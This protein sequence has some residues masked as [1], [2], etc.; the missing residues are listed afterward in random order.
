MSVVRLQTLAS[1]RQQ[2]PVHGSVARRLPGRHALRPVSL[3]VCLLGASPL[4]FALPEG[5]TPTHGQVTVQTPAAGQMLIH[6]STARA[7]LDWTSFSIAAGERVQVVQ[8]D[9]SSVLLNRVLGDNPSQIYGALQSNGSVWLINPRGIVFGANSR[10][11]VGGLVASTLTLSEDALSSGRLQLGMGAGGAGEL[12]S[13]GQITA[14]DGTVA[15]VAPRLFHTGQIEAR[16]V[17]LAAASE[18]LVDVEGDGLVFFNVRNDALD[19]RLEVL[20][21]VRA[22]GG[23]AEFRAAARAGFAD[24]VLNL[25]GVVQARSLGALMGRVVVDGGAS[26]VTRIG[27]TV[28]ATGSQGRGGDVLVQGDKILLTDSA[29]LDTSGEAGGGRLRV[30]GG[31]Q[32]RDDSVRNASMVNVARGARL[33]ANALQQGDGGEL[34]VWSDDATRFFG[35]ADARGGLTGGNGGL[36]E[37]SGKHHLDFRGSSDR[38]A[39]LGLTGLLLL[40]PTNLEIAADSP[41]IDGSASP[42]TNDL[43]ALSLLFAAPGDN[44]RITATAVQTQLGLGNVVLQ[45]NQN[46]SVNAP[47]TAAGANSLTLQAGNNITVGQPITLGGALTLSASDAGATGGTTTGAVAVNAAINVTGT[48]TLTRVGT[49]VHTVA[50][51]LTAGSLALTGALDVNG[52]STWALGA[53]LGTSAVAV[54]P[55]G[56]LTIPATTLAAGAVVSVEAG[57][58]LTNNGANTVSSLALAGT[59]AGNTV[60][61]T[62]SAALAGGSTV[63]TALTAS[64]DVTV[65]GPG[66]STVLAAVTADNILVNS[67]TL[68]V[69]N[70]GAAGSLTATTSVAVANAA[71]LAFNRSGSTDLGAVGGSGTVRVDGGTLRLTAT[72]PSVSNVNVLNGATLQY[73]NGAVNRINTSATLSVATGGTLTLGD[74]NQEVGTLTLGGTLTA[75]AQTLK[76]GTYNLQAGATV[77][78]PLDAGTLIVQGNATLNAASAA[79]TITVQGGATLTRGATGD[80]A[81]GADVTVNAGGSL[82]LAANDA[83]NSLALAGTLT[84]AGTLTTSSATLTAGTVDAALT[85]TGN[86]VSTGASVLQAAVSAVDV[87]INSGSLTIGNGGAAGALTPSGNLTVAAGATL[88]IN[89]TGAVSLGTVAGAGSVQVSL[90]TVTLDGTLPNVA[91]VAVNGGSLTLADN[92]ATRINNGANLSLA[93]GTTLTLGNSAETINDLTLTGATVTGNGALTVAGNLLSSGNSL[94]TTT[95]NVTGTSGVATGGVLTVGSGTTG[96]FA[97]TGTVTLTGTGALAYNGTG[98]FALGTVAGTGSIG[99]SSGALTING[100]AASLSALNATGGS[101]ALA[102]GAAQLGSGLALSVSNGASFTL[103]NN[104]EAV[105]TLTLGGTLGSATGV[106]TAT[107]YTLN[108]GAQVNGGLGTGS[109]DVQGNA[110]IDSTV[111][112]TSV[113]VA[114]GRTLQL[115]SNANLAAGATVAVPATATLNLGASSDTVQVLNLGGTLTGGATRTLNATTHNLQGG[116]VVNARLGGTTVNV[117][118]PGTVTLQ[119][120]LNG[121]GGINVNSGT[122]ALDANGLL[123]TASTLTVASGA[124]LSMGGTAS[125]DTLALRGTVSGANALSV[126]TFNATQSGS[127][128]RIETTVNV[129][130]NATVANGVTLTL[131]GSG[132]AGGAM[133]VSGTLTLGGTLVIDRDTDVLASALLGGGNNIGDAGSGARTLRQAGSGVFTLDKNIAG[134]R[135]LESAG[136]GSLTLTAGSVLSDQTTINVNSGGLFTMGAAGHT[137]TTLNLSGTLAGSGTLTANAANIPASATA[138]L[139]GSLNAPVSIA[140]SAQLTLGASGAIA[141]ARDVTVA[142]GATLVLARS[143]TIDQLNL[144]GTLQGNFTLTAT[145]GT[146]MSAGTIALGST[147]AGGQLLV[148][149]DATLNGRAE[150]SSVRI[151]SPATLTLGNTADRLIDTM[152]VNIRNGGTLSLPQDEVVASKTGSGT[153]AGPGRLITGVLVLEDGDVQGTT[154]ESPASLITNGAVRITGNVT[155]TSTVDVQSGVL[156]VGSVNGDNGSLSAGGTITVQGG[157]V[158]SYNR[159]NVASVTLAGNY[160]GAGT[161]RN[162]NSA[163]LNITGS[164]ALDNL[165]LTGGNVTVAS[166]A[167]GLGTNTAVN[168]AASRTLTIDNT[169]S[170]ASLTLNGTLNGSG[171]LTANSYTLNAGALVQAALGA[172]PMTVNGAATLAAAKGGGTL[173]VAG[174]G[175]LGITGGPR[176][177]AGA[178]VVIVTGGTLTLGAD[179]SVNSLSAG[180]TLAGSGLTLTSATP[181]TLSSGGVLSANVSANTLNVT[182]NSTLNGSATVTTLAVNNGTLTLAATNDR[183]ADT[184]NVSVAAGAVLAP[185]VN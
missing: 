25:D 6:Q 47:I 134:L 53:A 166:G 45:A 140:S 106:L 109:I 61:S 69:G 72:L 172:G 117:A 149:G 75:S 11:D 60:L 176:L 81:A 41:D 16:R 143:E 113:S 158:L 99:V 107:T 34:I 44:S 93:A 115:G 80:L 184:A 111:N 139:N 87:D 133:P 114:A 5:A 59:L 15:L 174:T 35:A 51:N 152:S 116:A 85:V 36:V 164:M 63:S 14:I 23:S 96:N 55:T 37:V 46:I 19:T 183:I 161:L 3:A 179:E 17:A 97:P 159:D 56:S 175:S 82:S 125:V 181:I 101:I 78:A 122:L 62:G 27:G 4:G 123:P 131:G 10:V 76:A 79:G 39:P 156:T 73:A 120:A 124:T 108:A 50:G 28:D 20:G 86:I 135:V 64:G 126:Q 49:G 119:Q 52:A 147:L 84:G 171:S 148:T 83:V 163:A 138:T 18:V 71:T 110:T 26:G 155:I 104:A 173:T 7:G 105:N 13:E 43:T 57:G 30:G 48:L 8:P 170:I 103:G 141:D 12:R 153:V 151:N 112:A 22:D 121:I 68:L 132:P 24:T 160:A 54:K 40:D 150:T 66:T 118:G 38:S 31:F 165:E 128:P 169:E 89:R 67:G 130:N 145:T 1:A 129:A 180:G 137:V 142:S 91:S 136:S 178:D 162:T 21:G 58:T 177:A 74:A 127:T 167:A 185:A 94:L 182:G 33:S 88:A 29:R 100:N 9:R 98:P 154:N 92:L 77:N 65:A 157:A 102:G 146:T 144:A 42:A 168:V 32:G 2:Q 70:G 95:V 90:G